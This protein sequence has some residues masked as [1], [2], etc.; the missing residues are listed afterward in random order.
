MNTVA[1]YS[2]NYKNKKQ[3]K[4]NTSMLYFAD[5][6]KKQQHKKLIQNMKTKQVPEYSS[7]VSSEEK[8]MAKKE[9]HK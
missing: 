5:M 8:G 1:R 4:V 7:F 6:H 9:Q 2:R 3:A